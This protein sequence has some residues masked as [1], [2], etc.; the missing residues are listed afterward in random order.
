M[1]S[2]QCC[3]FA[4]G[5]AGKTDLEEAKA[6]MIAHTAEE[7]FATQ[8]YALLAEMQKEQGK[9]VCKI[10]QSHVRYKKH[11]KSPSTC[12]IS[13]VPIESILTDGR[14]RKVRDRYD[15]QVFSWSGETVQ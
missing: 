5:L 13:L 8:V 9:R 7:A 1:C 10:R 6:E 3:S 12:T 4:P 2:Q 14:H 11:L 15:A